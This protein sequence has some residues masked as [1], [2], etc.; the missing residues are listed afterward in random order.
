MALKLRMERIPQWTTSNW[1]YR[2]ERC[3]GCGVERL[4]DLWPLQQD[5][6]QITN[7]QP[8]KADCPWMQPVLA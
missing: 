1:N 7:D 2:W 5:F 3:T 8:H 6:I 4:R